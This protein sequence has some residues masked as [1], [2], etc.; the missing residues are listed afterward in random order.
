MEKCLQ[1]ITTLLLDLALRVFQYRQLDLASASAK[2]EDPLSEGLEHVFL[3]TTCDFEAFKY[4]MK[5]FQA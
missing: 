3:I 5:I 1:C 2:K 4:E